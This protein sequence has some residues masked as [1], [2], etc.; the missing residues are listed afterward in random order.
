M[1]PSREE[2]LFARALEKP[3]ASRPAFLDAMC[4]GDEALRRRLEALLSAHAD[5]DGPMAAQAEVVVASTLKIGSEEPHDEAIGQVVGRYKLLGKVGEG[6][7]GVVYVAAQTEPVHRRVAL[8]VIKLGMAKQVVA[9]FEAER[10]CGP[11]AGLGCG[12]RSGGPVRE[13]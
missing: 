11:S 2:A 5:R 3:A 7:C 12:R 8:K 4:D 9:R 6:G 1:N 10:P 13:F